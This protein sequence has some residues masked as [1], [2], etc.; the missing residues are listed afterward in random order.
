MNALTLSL[1]CCVVISFPPLPVLANGELEMSMC[2][3]PSV[4][5]VNPPLLVKGDTPVGT[6]HL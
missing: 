3:V 4:K 2:G 6:G 5:T 1:F